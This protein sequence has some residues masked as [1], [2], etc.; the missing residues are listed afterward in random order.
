M[1]KYA[2]VVAKIDIKTN[3]IEEGYDFRNDDDEI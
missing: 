3:K 1:L 2:L